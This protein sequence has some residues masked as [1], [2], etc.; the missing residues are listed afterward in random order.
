MGGRGRSNRPLRKF[1][2]Q[3]YSFC[4]RAKRS[5]TDSRNYQQVIAPRTYQIPARNA[6]ETREIV[7]TFAVDDWRE[8]RKVYHGFFE[9]E[10]HAVD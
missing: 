3:N 6:Q 1:W 4:E 2:G 10:W 9:D 8:I 7:R 5:R